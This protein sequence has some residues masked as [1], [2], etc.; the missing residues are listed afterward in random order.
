[1]GFAFGTARTVNTPDTDRVFS[2]YL[3][4]HTF[5]FPV[6]GKGTLTTIVWTTHSDSLFGRD[7]GKAQNLF[8]TNILSVLK[9]IVKREKENFFLE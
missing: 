6:T 7:F 5:T 4:A 9:G 2:I 3:M 8:D 1:M